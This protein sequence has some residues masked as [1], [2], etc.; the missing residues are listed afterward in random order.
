MKNAGIPP[1]PEIKRRQQQHSWQQEK[2]DCTLQSA[3]LK[4]FKYRFSH[5]CVFVCVCLFLIYLSILSIIYLFKLSLIN[6]SPISRYH[7][8]NYH[9][10]FSIYLAIYR[11]FIAFI[12][13]ISFIIYQIFHLFS[14]IFLSIHPSICMYVHINT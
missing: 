1:D 3:I 8:S 2:R 14:S 13:S 5:V 10:S 6:P 9:L 12:S 7:L 11:L 4:G